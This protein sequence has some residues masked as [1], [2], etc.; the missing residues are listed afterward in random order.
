MEA[1]AKNGE[2]IALLALS[3][4]PSEHRLYEVLLAETAAA[5]TCIGTFSL[6]RLMALTGLGSYS[7]IKRARA[8]LVAKRSIDCLS[9]AGG[10]E[11]QPQQPQGV[12]LIFSPQEI[13]DRRRQSGIDPYPKGYRGKIG[14]AG[15]NLAIER[16]AQRHD[17]SRR[18]AQVALCCAGGLS[19]SEI[20][21]DLFITEQTVKF[22]LRHV[23]IK[24]GVKR[25]G[26]LISRLLRQGADEELAPARERSEFV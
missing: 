24:F 19:N 11:L 20:A 21:A 9:V 8:G 14:E 26:E 7:T 25:R 23:F 4:T 5:K 15:F 13:F 12:Y 16:L 17:L 22:H 10:A 3:H 2:S 1:L 18:E 6:R